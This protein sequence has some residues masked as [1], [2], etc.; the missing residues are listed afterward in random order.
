VYTGDAC[1][2]P[3]V[4]PVGNAGPWVVLTGSEIRCSVSGNVDR[5]YEVRVR[6]PGYLPLNQPLAVEA[7]SIFESCDDIDLGTLTVRR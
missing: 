6:C 5:V 3:A 2:P 1:S 4:T 7:C